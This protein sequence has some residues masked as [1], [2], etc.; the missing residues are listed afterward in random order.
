[1][2]AAPCCQNE[3]RHDKGQLEF[4]FGEN[5]SKHII[6]VPNQHEKTLEELEEATITL[7]SNFHHKRASELPANMPEIT[8]SYATAN[9]E[10]LPY[11]MPENFVTPE[12]LYF[13]H[14]KGVTLVFNRNQI[15]VRTRII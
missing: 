4:N 8:N 11:D 6:S 3:I 12:E 2:G 14:E 1:M 13:D 9:K 15:K 5:P 7:V 10:H